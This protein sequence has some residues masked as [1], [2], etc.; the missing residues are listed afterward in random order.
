VR[1]SEK[2]VQD[3]SLS[4]VMALLVSLRV[5]FLYKGRQTNGTKAF[6]N[7]DRSLGGSLCGSKKIDTACSLEERNSSPLSHVISSLRHV[8]RPI[9]NRRHRCGM[10]AETVYDLLNKTARDVLEGPRIKRAI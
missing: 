7:I 2:K 5:E 4:W 8:T 1:T 3:T 10:A 6:A 9:A